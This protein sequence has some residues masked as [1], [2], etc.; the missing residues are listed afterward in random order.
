M[1][2][3]I[4]PP[5]APRRSIREIRG[6]TTM[7]TKLAENGHPAV[8]DPARCA[9]RPD[10]VILAG[11]TGFLGKLLARH[12]ASH[13]VEVVVL[14]R[15]AEVGIPG[16]RVVPWDGCQLGAWAAELEGSNLVVNLCGRSVNCRYHAANRHEIY[17]SR[18]EPTRLLGEAIARC[19]RPPQLWINA[20]SAT[21]YRHAEDREMTE[22][23]GEIG[24]GFS[25]DVCQRWES[26]FN[27]ARTPHTRKVAL[28][29]AMVLGHDAN[30]VFP[31][32]SRLV[33]CGLG[34]TLG[35][36]RQYVSWLHEADFLGIID[37]IWSHDELM[38]PVNACAPFPVRNRE[39]MATLRK[40]HRMPV[41]LPATRLMLE[42]GAWI[43][44]TETELILKSRRVVPE[45]LL[46]SG[47]RFQFPHLEDAIAHLVAA[48]SRG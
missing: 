26:V 8:H 29:S 9:A 40:A 43:L 2:P 13:G 22:T 6:Y 41:G 12:F 15:R 27:E 42:A 44:G 18:L 3:T 39:L 28:R 37:W 21:I 16:A 31:T 19:S 33:R 36:G 46:D 4:P 23:G 34:G 35:S 45:R 38:C 1:N 47:Y 30:S 48:S 5:L 7:T 10:K 25:V 14:S 24:S 20:S 11:G 32:L 17:T